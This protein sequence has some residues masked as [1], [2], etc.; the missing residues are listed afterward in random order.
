M[1]RW[2]RSRSTSP[3]AAGEIVEEVKVPLANPDF[4]PFLQRMKDAKPDANVRVRSG[5]PGRANFM[6]QYAERGLDKSW[7]QGD[8]GRAT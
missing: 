1:T 5:R 7:H 4:A 6:K 3:P 8:W 2:L